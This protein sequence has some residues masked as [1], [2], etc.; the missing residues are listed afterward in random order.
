MFKNKY[1]SSFCRGEY[2]EHMKEKMLNGPA[3]VQII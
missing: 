1:I 2:L 3:S